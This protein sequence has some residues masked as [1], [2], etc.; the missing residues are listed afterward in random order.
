LTPVPD[1]A[2]ASATA[3]PV[4]RRQSG[5]EEVGHSPGERPIGTI[6]GVN[7]G[8]R[9]LVVGVVGVARFA[10]VDSYVE[11]LEALRSDNDS[12]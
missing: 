9:N 4:P 11:T 12:F 6:E 10:E 7:L 3:S 1:A 2:S 5:P 8:D